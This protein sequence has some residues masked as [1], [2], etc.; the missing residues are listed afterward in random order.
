MR[1]GHFYDAGGYVD[2]GDAA[3]LFPVES[4]SG[5]V[6]QHRDAQIEL[7]SVRSEEV[8]VVSPTGLAS[9]HFLTQHPITAV[10]IDSLPPETTATI[11]DRAAVDLDAFEVIQIGRRPAGVQNH[12][13]GE[14]SAQQTN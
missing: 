8:L 5:G 13:L 11:A 6:A 2:H 1:I 9:G 7:D 14:Y 12:S 4:L 3:S 10:E